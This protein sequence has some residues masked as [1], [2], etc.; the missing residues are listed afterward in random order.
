MKT[1]K[2]LSTKRMLSN[3]FFL[4]RLMFQGTPFYAFSIVVEA[5]RHNLVNFL[6]QTICVYLILDV[7]ETKK[8][9]TKVLWVVGLFL[10]LD[11]FAAAVS[12][13]YE[14]K[15]KLKYLPI[16]QKKLKVQG[17]RLEI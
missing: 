12:N 9:Y 2:G 3:N 10:L 13:L 16:A 15:I 4:L 14:Q 17:S 6:E 1:K 11:F 7:I 5:I 8:P